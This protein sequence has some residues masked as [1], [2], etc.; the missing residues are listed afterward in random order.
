MHETAETELRLRSAHPNAG[1][2]RTYS[3]SDARSLADFGVSCRHSRLVGASPGA[4]PHACVLWSPRSPLF[5]PQRRLLLPL[6]HHFMRRPRW[7]RH[8]APPLLHH[9]H[10]RYFS[11]PPVQS[12]NTLPPTDAPRSPHNLRQHQSLPLVTPPLASASA[13]PAGDA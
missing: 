2:G 8:L 10:M 13:A 12:A 11:S 7:L 1:R 4:C 3:S 5:Q 9:R 6:N